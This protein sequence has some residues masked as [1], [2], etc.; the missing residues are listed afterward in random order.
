MKSLC[1]IF[2]RRRKAPAPGPI[3]SRLEAYLDGKYYL[4]PEDFNATA[5]RL[6]TDTA[7]LRKYFQEVIGE[8]FRTWRTRLRIEEAK[9][10]LLKE[11]GLD[12]C[13]IGYLTGFEKGNFSRHF[14]SLTGYTPSEWR[15]KYS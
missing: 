11:P 15:R 13:R 8:D 6:G 1:S 3:D 12:I 5:V 10:L 14:R 4:F 9:I 2:I 7:T